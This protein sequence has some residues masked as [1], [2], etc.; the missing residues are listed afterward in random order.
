MKDLISSI[1]I[2][3][4]FIVASVASLFALGGLG[5]VVLRDYVLQVPNCVYRP[6]DAPIKIGEV[7]AQCEADTKQTKREIAERL[8]ILLIALPLALVLYRKIRVK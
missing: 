5:N 1:A 6:M 3:I 2:G 7:E 8:S 4:V